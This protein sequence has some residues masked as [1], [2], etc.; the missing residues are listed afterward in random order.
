[1]KNKENKEK[2]IKTIQDFFPLWLLASLDR[3]T[4]YISIFTIVVR[5][6]GLQHKDANISC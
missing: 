3:R 6:L 1:M 4:K 5:E 2:I